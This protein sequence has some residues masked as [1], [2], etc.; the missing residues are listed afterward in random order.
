MDREAL[1][2]PVKSGFAPDPSHSDIVGLICRKKGQVTVEFCAACPEFEPAVRGVCDS[3]Q[4]EG[5]DGIDTHTGNSYATC[6]WFG[7]V[8]RLNPFYAEIRRLQ[9]K[10]FGKW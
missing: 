5:K 2:F 8:L 7:E 3:D 4:L 6:K 1:K 10:R 9:E